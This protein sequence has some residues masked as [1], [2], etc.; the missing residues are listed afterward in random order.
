MKGRKFCAD[1]ANRYLRFLGLEAKRNA[2]AGT[3]SGGMKRKL[4]IAIAFIGGSEVVMLD[5]PS[6]GLDPGAR[7]DAWHLLQAE[8]SSRTI[9][10]TTHYME[11]ADLLGDR[12]VST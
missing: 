5:E 3:L 2:Y 8:K 1:E 6:S 7:H 11:E 10:L 9:L 12:I 4:S